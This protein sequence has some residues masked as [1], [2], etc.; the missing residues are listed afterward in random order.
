MCFITRS[1]ARGADDRAS[2]AAFASGTLYPSPPSQAGYTLNDK[3]IV[4]VGLITVP[5]VFRID[6][7][8]R[9]P[10]GFDGSQ[11]YFSPET[12]R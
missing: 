6:P 8:I 11:E 3:R 4:S 10:D 1:A 7:T 2:H 5:S 9:E 12:C